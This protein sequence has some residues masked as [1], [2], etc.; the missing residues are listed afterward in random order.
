MAE[1]A[2]PR[3]VG[4]AGEEFKSSPVE[5]KGRATKCGAS[6]P[7]C[8]TAVRR[9]PPRACEK[10]TDLFSLLPGGSSKIVH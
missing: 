4:H 8:C 6:E 5:G 1:Q 2:L 10:W 9:L 7:D 3:G